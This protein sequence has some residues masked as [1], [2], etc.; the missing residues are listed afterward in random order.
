MVKEGSDGTEGEEHTKATRDQWTTSIKEDCP[1]IPYP[2]LVGQNLLGFGFAV[3]VVGYW[4]QV[5][6]TAVTCPKGM[7]LIC[8]VIFWAMGC[9]MQR[10][11]K[12]MPTFHGS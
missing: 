5:L 11:Q 10:S 7:K 8:K 3:S 12:T 2:F 1:T 6:V 4:D 9:C